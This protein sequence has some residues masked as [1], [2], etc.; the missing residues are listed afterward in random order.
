M[1]LCAQMSAIKCALSEQITKEYFGDRVSKLLAFLATNG[2]STLKDIIFKGKFPKS[3][4][5]LALNFLRI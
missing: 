1:K 5:V 3:K 4:V 2:T